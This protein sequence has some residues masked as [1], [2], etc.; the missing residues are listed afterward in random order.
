MWI[1]KVGGHYNVSITF[2]NVS[3]TIPIVATCYDYGII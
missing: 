3:M 1:M 2:T